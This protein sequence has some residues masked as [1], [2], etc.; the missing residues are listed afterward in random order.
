M[1]ARDL[2]K[3]TT[4]TVLHNMIAGIVLIFLVQWAVPG[5]P[6]QRR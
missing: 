1:T 5:K 4:N 2:I 3:V 6:A